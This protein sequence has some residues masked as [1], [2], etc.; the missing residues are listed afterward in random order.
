[1]FG[2]MLPGSQPRSNEDYDWH[3]NLRFKQT[4]IFG[5]IQPWDLE[6]Y[7]VEQCNPSQNWTAVENPAIDKTRC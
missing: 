5:D 7:W 2:Q 6:R 4:S 3:Y 1:M